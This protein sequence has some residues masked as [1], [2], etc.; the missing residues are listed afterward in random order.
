VSALAQE[1]IGLAAHQKQGAIAIHIPVLVTSAE[2]YLRHVEA[3]DVDL[4]SGDLREGAD[5]EKVDLLRFRK[6]LSHDPP[7]TPQDSVAGI[8]RAKQRTLFVASPAGLQRLLRTLDPVE[9]SNDP[10]MRNRR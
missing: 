6:S 7:L 9:S 5:F 8:A 10:W 2:L 1:E 3:E 4:G